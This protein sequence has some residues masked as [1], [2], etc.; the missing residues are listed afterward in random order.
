[1]KITVRIIILG[2]KMEYWG[3]ILASNLIKK[4]KKTARNIKITS[5]ARKNIKRVFVFF[6]RKGIYLPR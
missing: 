4:A 6:I 3:G 1:V 5:A 2:I